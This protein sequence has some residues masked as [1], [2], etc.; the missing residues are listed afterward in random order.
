MN[1]F[2]AAALSA[3]VLGQ[4]A[5]GVRHSITLYPIPA[6][7]GANITLGPDKALWFS[8]GG[9]IT[10]IDT[11]GNVTQ[12]DVPGS[13]NGPQ[14]IVTGPD[15]ALWFAGTY[16]GLNRP[17]HDSGQHHRLPDTLG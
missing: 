8:E 3:L 16:G 11:Q 13:L 17:H 9:S 12:Y 4:S 14:E 1:G 2:L 15:G 6:P 10:R 7:G 5:P